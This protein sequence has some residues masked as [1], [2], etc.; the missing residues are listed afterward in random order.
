MKQ[1]I[2]NSILTQTKEIYDRIAP[3]FSDTRG[4]WWRGMGSFN[5]YVQPGD[6]V[7]DV[8]CGNGRMAEIFNDSKIEYLGIDNSAELIK[9]AKERFK[10]KPWIKFEVS[11]MVDGSWIKEAGKYKLV[12][13]IAVL[14]HLPTK[15]L[16][17]KVLENINNVLKPGGRLVMMNW[18][19]WQIFGW[20]KKF[21]YYRHLFNFREKIKR[22]TWGWSDAYVPWK[23]TSGETRRY[24][25]SFGRSEIK[26]LLKKAGFEVESVEFEV[27]GS[28]KTSILRGDNS[29]AIAIKK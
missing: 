6:K 28:P 29:I 8:G 13:M 10:D 18:N 12:L 2:V 25:Y 23:P 15:E 9:I 26:K 24:I 14:H 21:R 27:K 17:L 11:D 19:L 3:D 20:K 5:K 1:S 4:K 16:R 22:G 7:L